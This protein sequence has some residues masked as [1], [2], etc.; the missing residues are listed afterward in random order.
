MTGIWVSSILCLFCWPLSRLFLALWEVIWNAQTLVSCQVM[1]VCIDSEC[2]PS[3]LSLF[4][5]QGDGWFKLWVLFQQ[6]S[7]SS[8]FLIHGKSAALGVQ[9]TKVSAL[10]TGHIPPSHHI[11]LGFPEFS[12]VYHTLSATGHRKLRYTPHSCLHHRHR[13]GAHQCSWQP[14]HPHTPLTGWSKTRMYCLRC[15]TVTKTSSHYQQKQW[16]MV[17]FSLCDRI[18]Q[19][20]SVPCCRRGQHPDDPSYGKPLKPWILIT[21]RSLIYLASGEPLYLS[22]SVFL[23]VKWVLW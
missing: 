10:G 18:C 22:V 16:W 14:Y 15:R 9:E 2:V 8:V 7:S 13:A 6:L 11:S 5:S 12:W 3:F 17:T 1:A 20:F 21:A 19:A 4:L 23:P